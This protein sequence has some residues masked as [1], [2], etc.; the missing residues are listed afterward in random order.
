VVA[1]GE[2]VSALREEV[3][4]V[5]GAAAAGE[6]A[7]LAGPRKPARVSAWEEALNVID[8]RRLAVPTK[9]QHESCR[10]VTEVVLLQGWRAGCG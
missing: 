3:R 1:T 9:R 7:Q 6:A 4:P 8:E 2:E 10:G 5:L